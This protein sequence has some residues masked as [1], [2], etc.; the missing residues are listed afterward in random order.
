MAE[1]TM[2]EGTDVPTEAAETA[3]GT[4]E[5]AA[6]GTPTGVETPAPTSAATGTSE[7]MGTSTP[8]ATEAATPEPTPATTATDLA[9]ATVRT[10]AETGGGG[11]LEPTGLPPGLLFFLGGAL[12]LVAAVALTYG[13]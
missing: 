8:V 2:G 7:P 6:T 5:P 1:P 13:R 9:T 12:V 11:A 10:V 4:P 3:S